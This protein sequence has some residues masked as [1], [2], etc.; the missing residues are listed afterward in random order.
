MD[1]RTKD[2]RTRE[3]GV[4]EGRH[5]IKQ[6][7][8]G[9]LGVAGL[10]IGII[11]PAFVDSHITRYA[12]SV[13]SGVPVGISI[14]MLRSASV[15]RTDHTVLNLIDKVTGMSDTELSE[16]EYEKAV[17]DLQHLSDKKRTGS[18]RKLVEAI[19]ESIREEGTYTP[20]QEPTQKK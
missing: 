4:S 19:L 13:G 6:V 12:I 5:R 20:I 16:A 7:L 15:R 11:G 2:I 10:G 8:R 3:T 14:G 9:S 17:S 18:Q 1:A